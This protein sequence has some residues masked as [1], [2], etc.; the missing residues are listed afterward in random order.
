M[1]QI[2]NSIKEAGAIL[3]CGHKNPDGDSLG[4]LLAL[5]LGLKSIG[6]DVTML[7]SDEIPARFK[8]LPGADDVVSFTNTR[9]DLAIAVDCG[10]REMLGTQFYA[11][12]RAEKIL[13]I[14]HHLVRDSFAPLS[15]VDANASSAGEL[16]YFLLKAIDVKVDKDIAH[17]IFTSIMV[18]SNSFRLVDLSA[19]TFE[20][21]SE[22]LRTGLKYSSVREPLY[23]S[24]SR[25]VELLS[26]LCISRCCFVSEGQLA[27]STITCG[28]LKR[29]GA[30]ESD[31]DPIAARL[32]SLNGVALAILF[33]EKESKKE[34]RVSMR[35]KS[36]INAALLAAAFG[37]GGHSGAA[38]CTIPNNKHKKL[39]LLCAARTLIKTASERGSKPF[40][41]SVSKLSGAL[42]VTYYKEQKDYEY[43]RV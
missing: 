38:G 21:C 32:N 17:N 20:I 22:L 5:G 33:R 43:D 18:E 23:R 2:K 9:A 12:E 40:T 39:E 24:V 6:K 26:A 42:P 41:D 31:A 3:V 14:D 34:L 27:Y 36:G 8:H 4:A 19:Q 28:D 37:G 30:C 16:V 7:C 15:L 1:E 25:E 35:A 13:E 11:F 10:S 29:V